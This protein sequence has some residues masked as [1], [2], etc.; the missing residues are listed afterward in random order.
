[1]QVSSIGHHHQGMK[2]FAIF[3]ILLIFAGHVTSQTIDKVRFTVPLLA[4]GSGSPGSFYSCSA[5][6]CAYTC[7][8]S[9]NIIVFTDIQNNSIC[10]P[11]IV[12]RGPIAPGTSM[13]VSHMWEWN[14]F[15]NQLWYTN[16]NEEWGGEIGSSGCQCQPTSTTNYSC[17]SIANFSNAVV[18]LLS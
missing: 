12:Y 11:R 14:P 16:P 3:L 2:Q 1:M 15:L 8:V 4:P 6:N 10:S 13:A 18:I 7:S 17:C 5:D 9:V